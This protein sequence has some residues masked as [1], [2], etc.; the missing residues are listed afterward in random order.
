M[1]RFGGR[2]LHLRP[3]RHPAPVTR[4][5]PLTPFA[6]HPVDCRCKRCKKTRKA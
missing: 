6:H 1:T 3:P 5:E 4:K 2:F